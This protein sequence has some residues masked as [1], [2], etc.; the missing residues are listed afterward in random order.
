MSA[1]T[2][3]IIL[4]HN[5]TNSADPATLDISQGELALNL[6]TGK[7]YLKNNTNDAVKCVNRFASDISDLSSNYVISENIIDNASGVGINVDP[8]SG[9]DLKT[10]NSVE[11][12]NILYTSK[13][14]GNGSNALL[15]TGGTTDTNSS[16][17]ELSTSGASSHDI[18]YDA[19]Q[20]I[21]RKQD[22]S[23]TYASL[24]SASPFIRIGGNQVSTGNCELRLGESRTGPGQSL[25]GFK[26]QADSASTTD[27]VG[28]FIKKHTN[29]KFQLINY[30]EDIILSAETGNHVRLGTHGAGDTDHAS[31]SLVAAF[32]KSVSRLDI[33]SF[34][35]K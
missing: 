24:G 16:Q 15:I 25:I 21:F 4:T 29:N 2:Q 13:I 30:D 6:S 8:Q 19:D 35:S 28:A 31:N 10:A 18:N 12:G 9:L 34:Q 20:H 17:I 3:K 23:Y 22:A 32:L 26:S 1:V 33:L 14:Y 27:R 5:K 7:I 11:I